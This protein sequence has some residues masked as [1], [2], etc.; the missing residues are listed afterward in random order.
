MST[1]GAV[2]TLVAGLVV[3]GGLLGL[4][5]QRGRRQ[6][7]IE[8]VA[9]PARLIARRWTPLGFAYDVEYPDPAGRPIRRD[10]LAVTKRGPRRPAVFAGQVWVARA[11]PADVMLEPVNRTLAAT[12]LVIA[13]SVVLTVAVL[14]A[15]TLAAF[16]ALDNLGT[17][18]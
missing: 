17:H 15:L 2:V 14:V 13:G 12:G 11:D 8:R 4:G 10:V 9:L 5:I 18:G 6:R 1:A 3:G 7:A 16:G